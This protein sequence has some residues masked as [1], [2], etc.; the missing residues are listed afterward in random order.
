MPVPETLFVEADEDHVPHQDGTNHFLKIVYVHEG[1]QSV[2]KKFQLIRPFYITGE[3]PGTAGTEE[4]WQT[5]ILH[6]EAIWWSDAQ[7]FF[8]GR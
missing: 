7:T 8:L 5:T 4:I 1:Y 2:G 3:Y 6:H